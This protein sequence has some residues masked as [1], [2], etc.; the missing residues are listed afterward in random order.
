MITHTQKPKEV[1]F[2]DDESF[3]MPYSVSTNRP[4]KLLKGS[5]LGKTRA[6]EST[7]ISYSRNTDTKS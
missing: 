6:C 2:P 3:I 7:N 1:T 5:S 4:L